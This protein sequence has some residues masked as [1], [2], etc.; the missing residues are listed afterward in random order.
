MNAQQNKLKEDPVQIRAALVQPIYMK[1]IPSYL[2]VMSVSSGKLR[3]LGEYATQDPREAIEYAIEFEDVSRYHI[4]YTRWELSE[5]LADMFFINLYRECKQRM[6][7][8]RLMP[9]PYGDNISHGI[10]LFASLNYNNMF[11]TPPDDSILYS[12]L[13]IRANEEPDDSYYAFHALRYILGGLATQKTVN[14]EAIAESREEWTNVKKAVN[15]TGMSL[16]A[17]Q[18]IQKV[19]QEQKENQERLQDEEFY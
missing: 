7:W 8:V 17:H 2:L 4:L 13:D 5:H 12:Q 10:E 1:R 15:L 16:S 11:E 18:Q 9:A 3:F 19:R 14:T 6:P